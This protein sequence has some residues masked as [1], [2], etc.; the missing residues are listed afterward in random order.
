[1][2]KIAVNGA[3]GKMGKTV[4]SAVSSEKDFVFVKGLDIQDDLSNFLKNNKVDVVVD[5]TSPESRMKNLFAILSNGSNA[6]IGTTGFT[7]EDLKQITKWCLEY[8]KNVIIGPNFAIGT[9]FQMYFAKIAAKHFETVEIVEYHHDQKIDYPSGTAVK[10]AQ[11]MAEE[12][13]QF[14]L[15]T[16]DKV[17]NIEGTRGGD[18][19]GIKIHSVR[20]PGMIAHQEVIFGSTGQYLTLRHDATSRECYMPGVILSIREV[21]KRKGLTYGLESILGLG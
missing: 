10:T 5:F 6:V 4:I 14:N 19:N 7:E 15:N 16:K 11:L 8:K 12:R 2:I 21:L 1:M 17:A 9:I 3:S 13:K 20:L 18:F